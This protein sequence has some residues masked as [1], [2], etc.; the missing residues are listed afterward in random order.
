MAQHEITAPCRLLN[1]EGNLQEPG[2]AKKLYWKYDR[3]D[4]KAPKWRIKEW[5]Y[6]YIGTQDWGR[7]V[8]DRMVFAEH[9]HNKW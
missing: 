6:Y 7:E 8:R 5:D 9:M 3:A 2:F 4:I 1:S